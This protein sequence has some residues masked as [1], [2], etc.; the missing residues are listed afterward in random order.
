VGKRE[1]DCDILERELQFGL[2]RAVPFAIAPLTSHTLYQGS[3]NR[4]LMLTTSRAFLVAA[5]MV[6]ISTAAAIAQNPSVAVPGA[7][8]LI[9]VRAA[10]TTKQAEMRIAI[11]G[12]AFG[13]LGAT[14]ESVGSVSL[15]GSAGTGTGTVV[16]SLLPKPGQITFSSD[17]PDVAL[18]LIVTALDGARRPMLSARGTTVCVTYSAA[19]GVGVQA[20]P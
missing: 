14:N 20:R 4:T 16:G 1:I 19:G 10:D 13:S 11:T 18:E 5:A 12:G 8:Y 15:R 9:R 3:S 17:T 7:Q 6:A 2:I